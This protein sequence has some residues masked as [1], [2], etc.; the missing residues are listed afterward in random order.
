MHGASAVVHVEADHVATASRSPVGQD[1]PLPGD[2]IGRLTLGGGMQLLYIALSETDPQG[3]W[4]N[5]GSI[6][7]SNC[8]RNL[9]YFD[10]G[11]ALSEGG[12]ALCES[13]RSALATTGSQFAGE[14]FMCTQVG[15]FVAVGIGSNIKRRTRSS[16]IAVRKCF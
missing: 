1:G 5:A 8:I 14:F 2:H 13:V 12:S 11:S 9:E 16:K 6:G 15:G 7:N 10:T 3:L 4:S